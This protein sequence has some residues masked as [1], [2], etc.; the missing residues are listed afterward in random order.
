MKPVIVFLVLTL[1]VWSFS[2]FA[3]STSSAFRPCQSE[4]I[5]N[6]I[7]LATS[8]DDETREETL[9]QIEGDW[10]I[11]SRQLSKNIMAVAISRGKDIVSNLDASYSTFKIRVDEETQ[12]CYVE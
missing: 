12:K 1:S 4:I 7:D 10:T 11:R 5:K 2:T 6:A 3:E 9:G 8:H